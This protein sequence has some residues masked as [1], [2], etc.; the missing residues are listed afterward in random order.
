MNGGKQSKKAHLSSKEEGERNALQYEP[1]DGGEEVISIR[2]RKNPAVLV[3][4]GSK[5]TNQGT[6]SEVL[7]GAIGRQRS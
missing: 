6:F 4:I 7:K 1:E 3:E 2:E 5:T